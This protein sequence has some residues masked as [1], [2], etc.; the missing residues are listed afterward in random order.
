M[1][2]PHTYQKIRYQEPPS[3]CSST[4]GMNYVLLFTRA[5]SFFILS[6]LTEI[7]WQ[8]QRKKKSTIYFLLPLISLLSISMTMA[9]QS[10]EMGLSWTETALATGLPYRAPRS[11]SAC[12]ASFSPRAFLIIPLCVYAYSSY[13][14]GEKRGRISDLKRGDDIGGERA[15]MNDE[16]TG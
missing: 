13:W 8:S 7:A 15:G 14:D 10:C 5:S 11:K 9:P 4:V 2:S 6:M 1:Y 12:A 3:H 16:Y